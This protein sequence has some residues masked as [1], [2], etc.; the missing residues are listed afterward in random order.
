MSRLYCDI[1][2]TFQN[3]RKKLAIA[4]ISSLWYKYLNFINFIMPPDRMIG[5]ILFLSCLFVSL[6]VC[7]YV[8]NFNI[9][10]S[11]WIVRGRDFIFS[12]HTPLIMPFH[13]TPWSMTLW[14]WLWPLLKQITF[15][16][17]C[18]RRRHSQC[19]T[20][21]PWFLLIQ[22]IVIMHGKHYQAKNN[23]RDSL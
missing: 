13:M 4:T 7:L 11:F 1:Q 12:M 9:R 19:F 23:E 8:V 10:Y 20:N 22:T 17:L 14:P 15:F 18:C 3:F 21:T 5:G 16:G 6:F 2:H